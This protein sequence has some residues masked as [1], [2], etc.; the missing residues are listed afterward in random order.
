MA[1]SCSKR[2][3][4]LQRRLFCLHLLPPFEFGGSLCKR[5]R[6]ISN[7]ILQGILF[8]NRSLDWL[9]TFDALLFEIFLLSLCLVLNS[10]LSTMMVLR[11]PVMS[12]CVHAK[13]SALALR[14][15][16]NSFLKCSGK[17][18]SGLLR[19]FLSF[20]NRVIL[21]GESDFT[22][23]KLRVSVLERGCS[24]VVISNGTSS[25]DQER[26]PKNPKRGD[27]CI[28][29]GGFDGRVLLLMQYFCLSF[30]PLDEYQLNLPFLS[31]C[32]SPDAKVALNLWLLGSG[33]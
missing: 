18:S 26:F 23:A 9:P 14:K 5:P 3:L 16:H 32:L 13:M 29:S 20:A 27:F 6:N 10:F 12:A 4:P 15:F 24:P 2:L 17:G 28:Y 25:T 19:F 30:L 11:I 1:F 21:C 22:M 31:L 8:S 7:E 33:L